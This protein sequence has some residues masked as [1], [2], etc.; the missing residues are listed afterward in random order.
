MTTVSQFEEWMRRSN[1]RVEENDCRVGRAASG[2]GC[3]HERGFW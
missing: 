1:T 3:H 2:R